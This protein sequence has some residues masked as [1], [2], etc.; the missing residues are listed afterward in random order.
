MQTSALV[1]QGKFSYLYRMESVSGR[2]FGAGD[3]ANGSGSFM[4]VPTSSN[5]AVNGPRKA[6]EK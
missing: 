4:R 3:G 2:F 6:I 1:V 5:N